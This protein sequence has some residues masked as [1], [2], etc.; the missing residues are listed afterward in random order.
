MNRITE[1]NKQKFEALVQDI[2]TVQGAEG[3]AIAMVDKAGQVQYEKYFGYRDQEQMLPIDGQ[4][5]FGLAS[6]TKSF[7]SLAIM[8]LAEQG[9]IN[10]S[11]PVSKYVPAFTNKNQKAPVKIWHLLCH[12]GG[13]FPLSRILVDQVAEDMGLKESE[14]GDL[15]YSKALA[16]EGIKRVASRLDDQTDLIGLPGELMSYCNDGFGV[17]SDIIKNYG[18]QPSFADYLLKH[19]IRPLGMERSF[20]DFVKP[21]LDVNASILYTKEDGVSRATRDYH[22]N[23]FVLNGGGAMK[24]TVSDM[25]KYICMYLNEGKGLN[26]T[27]IASEYSIREMCKPR[28][29]YRPGGWYC[30]GLCRKSMEE[31]DILEH[32]GSLPGVS[33][34]MSWSYDNEVGVIVLCNTMD[35]SAGVIAD[36]AMR[37]YQGK[38]PV[39]PKAEYR[40]HPWS[41]AFIRSVSGDY[42]TGEGDRFTL[43]MS[44]EGT[45]AMNLNGKKKEV[46]TVNPYTAI[47]KGRYSDGF[48]QI[49]HDEKRGI[50]GARCGSRIYS[51][52]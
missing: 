35:V 34:N 3:V 8:K 42:V 44:E 25:L 1:E 16:Q 49:L 10:L 4:T 48:V 31:L 19:I 37:M 6:I 9:V 12:S 40:E 41:E 50:W 17:L 2:M 39:A 26:G 13:F 51:K 24:S 29:Y 32:G 21:S 33:S 14:A 7:T 18:D 38:D 22:D 45:L 52:M 11:D 46:C 5:I 20:C 30:Y 43:T 27:R 23:A 28:Q 36:G 15:A 47:I